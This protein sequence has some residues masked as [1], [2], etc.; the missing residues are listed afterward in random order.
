[1]L[2]SISSD[3]ID[4]LLLRGAY[5]SLRFMFTLLVCDERSV[6]PIYCISQFEDGIVY[7]IPVC[8]SVGTLSLTFVKMFFNL[9]TGFLAATKLCVCNTR[10][11]LSVTLVWWKTRVCG[12][13]GMRICGYLQL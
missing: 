1:M 5:S 13:A 9:T 6:S 3:T 12:Y 4:F 7:T 10:F 2:H 8:F 11:N